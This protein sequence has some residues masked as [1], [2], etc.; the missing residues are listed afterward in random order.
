MSRRT[1]GRCGESGAAIAAPD[2]GSNVDPKCLILCPFLHLRPVLE[3]AKDPFK[4]R[5]VYSE[6]LC[7]RHPVLS[8]GI[9]ALARFTSGNNISDQPGEGCDFHSL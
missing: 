7:S 8:A 3:E 1:A 9:A 4:T 5:A 6:A 2:P